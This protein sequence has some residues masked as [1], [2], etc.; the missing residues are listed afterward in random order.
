MARRSILIGFLQPS[1]ILSIH[2]S[3]GFS[4]RGSGKL[5]SR[6]LGVV[7]DPQIRFPQIYE[8]YQHLAFNIRHSAVSILS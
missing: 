2:A 3:G 6:S 8:Q 4:T 7:L 5:D 1:S